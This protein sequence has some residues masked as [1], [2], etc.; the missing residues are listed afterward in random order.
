MIGVEELVTVAE[1]EAVR[2][3]W[4]RLWERCPSATPFQHP[5]WLLPWCRFFSMPPLFVLAVR[6]GRRLVGL[7]P[8]SIS[9]HDGAQVIS[10]LGEGVSDYLDAIFDPGAA[11]AGVHGVLAYLEAERSRWDL[12]SFGRLRARSPL[13]EAPV[14]RGWLEAR[15]VE[16]ICPVLSARRD[17]LSASRLLRYAKHCRR[18][19][20]RLGPVSLEIASPDDLG[21]SIE[22]LFALHGARWRARGEPGVL[23]QPNVRR[24]HAEAAPELLAAGLL[25]LHVLRIAGR[26]VAVYY[27]LRAHGRS[28][29]YIG[30]FDPGLERLSP[31]TLVLGSA[32]EEAIEAGVEEIDFLRGRESYKYAWGARD[33]ATFRRRIWGRQNVTVMPS[34][35]REG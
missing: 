29:L 18:R 9:L 19:A 20:E 7:A 26:F 28:Y 5:A 12:C 25:R 8:M 13:L 31:G 16:E 34:L 15:E 3:E 1:L 14:P 6:D 4:A 11:G 21:A 33:R 32:I 30:G 24:F 23:S 27:E 35:G 17:G 10:L 2:E 22:A